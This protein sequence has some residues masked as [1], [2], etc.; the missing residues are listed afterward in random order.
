MS[1]TPVTEGSNPEHT[2]PF[3]AAPRVDR[4]GPDELEIHWEAGPFSEILAC[5]HPHEVGAAQGTPVGTLPSSGRRLQGY[6][7]HQRR[8]FQLRPT[9]GTP[10]C[11]VAERRLALDGQP[12]LRDLGGYQTADGRT[13]RWGQL[14]RSGALSALTSE[15]RRMV[16][17]LNLRVVC[18]F[19]TPLERKREPHEFAAT[20]SPEQ[21]AVSREQLAGALQPDDMRER[22]SSGN[23]DELDI[24][25][26]LVDGNDAFATTH[27]SPFR[28]MMQVAC[29][30]EN[31][32]LLV[33][34]TAGKDRAGFAAA[35]LLMALGVPRPTIQHDYLLSGY[36]RREDSLQKMAMIR[37]QLPPEVDG[38]VLS[39][40]FETR[41]AYIEAAFAAID[42]EWGSD[43]AFLCK[44]LDLD[45]KQLTVLRDHLLN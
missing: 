35:V 30:A 42:R 32:P 24:G 15:D 21:I 13:V 28:N 11:W 18:D 26:L 2:P 12:N 5:D 1:Q 36:F 31:Y 8:Y 22:M 16:G 25:T 44:G 4:I 33:N 19:R 38:S 29:A 39:P 41:P 23:F 34:C 20:A 40:L 43:E 9:D 45:P 7:R 27:R 37:Q 10:P 6:P 3:G 17:A 14:F